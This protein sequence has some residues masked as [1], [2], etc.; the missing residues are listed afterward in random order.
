MRL[1][2]GDEGVFVVSD[3]RGASLTTILIIVIIT[4]KA[5]D[6]TIGFEGEAVVV[7]CGDGGGISYGEI[8]AIEDCVAPAFYRGGGGGLYKADVKNSD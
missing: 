8:A 5:D 1:L 7:S 2:S 3:L 4:P 6:R